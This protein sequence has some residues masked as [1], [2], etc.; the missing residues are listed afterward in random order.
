MHITIL[1]II[2]LIQENM[3]NIEMST[4][5]IGLCMCYF[6]ILSRIK[7]HTIYGYQ[8]GLNVNTIVKLSILTP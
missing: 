7:L 1:R 6:N 4:F 8:H 3:R 5:T 2:L